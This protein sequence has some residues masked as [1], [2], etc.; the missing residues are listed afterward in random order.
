LA[1]RAAEQARAHVSF[2]HV[3]NV[4]STKHSDA[5]L[6]TER[7]QMLERLADQEIQI[8]KGHVKEALL[9]AAQRPLADALIIGRPPKH[10]L[11]GRMRDLTYGLIRDSPVPVLSI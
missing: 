5:G 3:N 9:G 10:G 6:D 4:S 8:V 7:K 11:L 1:T 2:I